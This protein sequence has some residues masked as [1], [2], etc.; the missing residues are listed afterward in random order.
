[1]A[2]LG[3]ICDEPTTRLGKLLLHLQSGESA[4][5]ALDIGR[6][7][8]LNA[9]TTIIESDAHRADRHF[10]FLMKRQRWRLVKRNQVP[11]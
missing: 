2:G 7:K 8:C 3:L 6:R 11:D 9:E 1:V 10:R 4:E 5:D